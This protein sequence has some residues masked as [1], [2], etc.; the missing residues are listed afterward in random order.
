MNTA[1]RSLILQL[2]AVGLAGVLHAQT[3]TDIG[4]APSP[5]TNDISQLSTQGNTAHPNEPD[6]LNYYTDRNPAP[7]QTFTTG[8][9]AMRLVSV[10]IK[11]AGLDSGLGYGTP[12][13]TPTYYLSI[14]SMSGSNATL[15]VTF[16]APNP[17]FTDGD[18]LKW[19][20]LNV[21]LAT[22]TTYAYSFGRLP[23]SGGY[24]ALAVATNNT[25]AGGEMAVIPIGG[26][27]ITTGSSHTFDAVFSL[28]L[29]PV[30]TP[31]VSAV[32]LSPA[33]NV[34]AGTQMTF[35]ASATGALP[36][37]YQ[38]QF[39]SGGGFVNL[40]GANT[41]ALSFSAAVTNS[42]SYQLVVTNSY[43]AVTS[44]PVAL[45]VTLDTNPPVV[46]R[47]FN[48]GTTNVEVDF[49]KTLETASAASAANYAF[50]NGQPVTSV[51]FALNGTSVLLGTTPLVYGSNYTVVVNGVRDQAVPPNSVAPNSAASFIASPRQRIL[52]DAGWRFQLGDPADVTTNVTYYPEI[53]NLW[54]FQAADVSGNT[55][56]TYYESVR[57]DIFATHAGE[58]VSF[59]KTNYDDSAWRS[60]DLPHDWA[61]ELPFDS[62]AQANHGFKPIGEDSRFAANN[63]GWYRRTFT[64]P[65]AAAGKSMGLDFGGVYRNSLVWLNG[66]LVG[67]NVSGYSPFYFDVTPYLNPGGT[68]VLV[69]RV[70]ASRY[71]GWW[72]E[73]AG[74]YR[75]VWLTTENPVHVAQ[76]GMFVKT[77]TLSGSNA[78]VSIQTE[79][80]NQGGS[81]T[82]GATLTS[83]IYDAT[84]NAVTSVTSPINI[85]AGQ[86]VVTTQSVSFAAN[87]WSL[88]NPYLYK[89]VTTVSNQNATADI[90]NTPFGVRTVTISTTNGVL[91][92]GKRVPLQGMCNHQDHAG[93]GTALPDRL[94]Y[95]R[96]ER[97]K[98]MGVNA[99]RTSH[100]IPTEELLDACDQVGMLV[101]DE[102]R[103]PGTNAEPMGELERQIRRDRN[104]PSIFMWCL[105]NEEPLESSSTGASIIQTMQ[106]LVHSMDPTRLCTA[107]NREGMNGWLSGFTTVI[108]VMGF[109]YSPGGMDAFHAALPNMPCIGTEISSAVGDRGVYA[110]AN[111]YVESYD[112]STSGQPAQTWVP[113]YNARPWASGAFSWTGFDYRGEPYPTGWPTI[114]SH[115]GTLDTCGF[116]KDNFYYY[117]ANWTLK[118]V[119][120][121]LPHWN[122]A[123]KEGQAI[124]VW[125]YGNCQSVELFLNGVSQGRQTLNTQSHLAWSV[126]YAAGTLQAV[127]YINGV[128]GITNT[129]VTT[130]VPAAITLTPDRSVISAN[131]VDISIITVAAVD[132]Q[133][134]VVPTAANQVN[135]SISVGTI[136]GVGNGDPNSH[137]A[138]KASQRSVFKGFAQVIVQSDSQPGGQI[139][140]R[141]E[142]HRFTFAPCELADTR[143][144]PRPE[145]ARYPSES[146]PCPPLWLSNGALRCERR[147]C[148][149]NRCARTP[150]TLRAIWWSLRDR[151]G[152]RDRGT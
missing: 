21:A 129:V 39:N 4:A 104:H 74:I 130:G 96:L 144:A 30:S 8:T 137:E 3:L 87:L 27:T 45:V 105:A 19:S 47:A 14:Y 92:N 50:A 64:L 127:G 10:A 85:P 22:N 113:Y 12:A 78:T 151:R 68:N 42:G 100:N 114:N 46:L 55:S 31:A 66:H 77:T 53:S 35:A 121:L 111:S 106:N 38:W 17:G 147:S 91:L 41:N 140:W 149:G 63:I 13:S 59:V 81:A 33:T 98:Q 145:A 123:G 82:S 89:L 132:S 75:H 61:V 57:P 101:L 20:G 71:E 9:N 73:G 70:D 109:N 51:L 134:R 65:A 83:T 133:G 67:R 23:G 7:G 26:G 115:F 80:T 32:T 44:A 18:W 117:Q 143:A 110:T 126:S 2:F 48:V 108:D 131:G 49:S 62:S 94:Q 125:A 116:A 36:L 148:A 69:V 97:L 43:G 60:L 28:G 11:T 16:S 128:P 52:L 24:A 86:S 37:Y 90:Y 99:Y 34:F 118:P 141:K 107:A 119:L 136:I 146:S 1:V 95:Y 93:V 102:N 72:Y 139:P 54:H 124:S 56:E 152:G 135:F 88:E 112:D 5:G 120:H 103:R 25:Y 15:L 122:W 40:P 150:G 138:D 6:N 76:W 58:D 142:S 84:G 79:V 29:Q